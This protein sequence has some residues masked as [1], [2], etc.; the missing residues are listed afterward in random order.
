[1]HKKCEIKYCDR[2]RKAEDIRDLSTG[3]RVK[4]TEK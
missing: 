1:M 2:K 3:K 4:N